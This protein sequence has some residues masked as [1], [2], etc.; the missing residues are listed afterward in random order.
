M[1]RK[2]LLRKIKALLNADQRA[3]LAKYDS[4]E[5]VLGQLEVKES[6]FREKLNGEKD[7]ERRKEILRKLEVLEAQ[8]KK[9][10]QLKKEIERLRDSE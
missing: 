9:G 10:V 1:K 8:R 7:E 3:Q 2:K 6:G 4:L 5:K